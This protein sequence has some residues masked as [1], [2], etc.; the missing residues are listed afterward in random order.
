[1]FLLFLV[2]LVVVLLF[3]LLRLFLLLLLI[4]LRTGSIY[5][6]PNYYP[7][8][9][10]KKSPLFAACESNP[11]LNGGTCHEENGEPEGFTCECLPH[12]FGLKCENKGKDWY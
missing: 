6:L 7:F 2:C 10:F 5:L 4:L 3:F 1:M 11:C 8:Y 9:I 12:F